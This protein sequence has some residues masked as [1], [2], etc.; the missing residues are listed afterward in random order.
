MTAEQI[1]VGEAWC[2]RTEHLPHGTYEQVIAWLN[3]D[4]R[5]GLVVRIFSSEHDGSVAFQVARG[6]VLCLSI[7]DFRSRYQ[8]VVGELCRP[9]QVAPERPPTLYDELVQ[10]RLGGW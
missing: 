5:P 2:L 1:S 3:A 8:R 4:P 7:E 9:E 6:Y 10:A